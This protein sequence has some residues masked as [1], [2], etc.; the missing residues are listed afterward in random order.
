M[1]TGENIATRLRVFAAELCGCAGAFLRKQRSS[2][3]HGSSCDQRRD[4]G[5][6][7]RRR[8]VLRAAPIH[9]RGRDRERGATRGVVLVAVDRRGRAACRRGP[10]GFDRGGQR[11][12]CDPDGFDQDGEAERGHF[13]WR[14]SRRTNREQRN[15]NREGERSGA[16][17]RIVTAGQGHGSV[18]APGP[19]TVGTPSRT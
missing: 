5:P 17:F 11:A 9:P 6:I 18:I 16:M 13:V 15:R 3:S 1:L 2:T 10:R 4:P 12:R 8:V 7:T 14:Q 19:G